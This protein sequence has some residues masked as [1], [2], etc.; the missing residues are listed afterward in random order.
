MGRTVKLELTDR[1]INRIIKWIMAALLA[2]VLI[3]AL[4]LYLPA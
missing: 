4:S 2:V 3:L 1:H